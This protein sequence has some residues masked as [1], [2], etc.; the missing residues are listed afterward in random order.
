MLASF[1]QLAEPFNFI[2]PDGNSDYKTTSGGV[3]FI[4]FFTLF[5]TYFLAYLIEFLSR[6]EYNLIE[7]HF[8]DDI[9][10]LIAGEEKRFGRE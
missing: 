3:A 8:E 2:L 1:D 9:G 5:G 4:L 6:Q 10:L 7:A